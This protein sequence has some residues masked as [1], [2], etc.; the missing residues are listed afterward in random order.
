[1]MMMIFIR[2]A[3]TK[4]RRADPEHQP[5]PQANLHWDGRAPNTIPVNSSSTIVRREHL[6]L[7]QTAPILNSS[8]SGHVYSSHRPTDNWDGEHMRR[9]HQPIIIYSS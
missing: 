9:F 3:I 8:R 6:Q 2:F 1:M 4:S 7:P 5:R